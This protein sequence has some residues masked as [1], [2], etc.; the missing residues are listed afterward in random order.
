MGNILGKINLLKFKNA[1]I[2]NAKIAGKEQ[3][4]VVVPIEDNDI[5]VSKGA[6]GE[7][8]GAYLDFIAYE[9]QGKYGESHTVK[10]N[11]PKEKRLAMSP[12]EQRAIPFIGFLKPFS[13]MGF[14]NKRVETPAGGN[15]GGQ[16]RSHNPESKVAQAK[17]PAR[18]AEPTN[19]VDSLPF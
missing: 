4:A 2:V 10:P 3:R 14:I 5:Y 19:I 6:N 13:S 8:K 1:S 17:A 15:N 18:Q 16:S 12:E 11:V 9:S 7:V